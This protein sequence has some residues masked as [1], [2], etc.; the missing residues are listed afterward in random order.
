[1]SRFRWAVE[2]LG[3]EID[4]LTRL[5]DPATVSQQFKSSLGP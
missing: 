5:A 1:M 4:R 3:L 2:K